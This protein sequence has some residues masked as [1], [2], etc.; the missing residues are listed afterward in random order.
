MSAKEALLGFFV[1]K[2]KLV[3]MGF[4]SAEKTNDCQN[5]PSCKSVTVECVVTWSTASQRDEVWTPV[6]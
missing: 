1:T 4:W 2:S 6:L 5:L 3:W